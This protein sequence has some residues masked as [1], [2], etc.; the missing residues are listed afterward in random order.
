[1]IMSMK[2]NLCLL[3]NM[4]SSTELKVIILDS[5]SIDMKVIENVKV[6]RIKSELYT[7][8]IMKD[9][10][11]VVGEI[12]GRISIEAEE[13]ITYE[14]INGFYSLSHNV[15]HLIIKEQGDVPNE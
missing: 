7:L 5:E 10:W 6:I 14:N 4:E 15:F 1:M 8:L 2:A 3:V 11:P 9:Y 13:N 12:N